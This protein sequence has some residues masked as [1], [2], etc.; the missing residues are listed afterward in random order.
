MLIN[1]AIF[2]ESPG[3]VEEISIWV[4]PRFLDM[5]WK[6]LKK[7]N[8]IKN[9][10]QV[11]LQVV[12]GLS[13]GAF[14]SIYMDKNSEVKSKY[15]MIGRQIFGSEPKEPEYQPTSLVDVVM[16]VSSRSIEPQIQQESSET[17]EREKPDLRSVEEEN[18]LQEQPGYVSGYSEK[19][20]EG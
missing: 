5:I 2:F 17:I 12:F 20:N 9:D 14:C 15:S 3:R 6:Y 7:K 16:Y 13:V 8:I 19:K 11:F 1:A 10:I 18:E 4:F